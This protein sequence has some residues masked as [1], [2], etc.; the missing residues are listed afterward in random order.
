MKTITEKAKQIPVMGAYDVFVAGGGIA[1]IAAALAAARAGAKV[2]LTEKQCILGGLATAGLVT[3]YLPLCDGCGK[4]VSFAI[5]EELLKLS[6]SYGAEDRYPKPW[7]EDGSD[8][9]KAEIRYQVRFNPHLFAIEAEK[10]LVAE[11]VKILYNTQI[12][13]TV[14]DGDKIGAV[15]VENKSGRGA[16]E[17]KSVVDATGDADICKFA[18]AKTDTFKP[19]NV[20][21]AWNYVSTKDGVKLNM[22]GYCEVPD[23]DK[24]GDEPAPL[25]KERFTGL[26]GEE[27]SNMLIM[28]HTQMLNDFKKKRKEDE[29]Y[30]PVTMPT[31]PQLRMTRRI[32]GKYVL[33]DK[34]MHTY[35][36]DSIGMICDWRKRG[37]VY[38]VPFRTLYGKEVKNLIC[39]GR[40]ISVTDNMWDVSRV[41]PP[42]AVTGQAAGTAAAMTDDFASLDVKE[43]QDKLTAS[44][45][46]LHECDL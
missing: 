16:Y 37:P 14:M 23:E 38:E 27:I 10:L 36:E 20:L 3:I 12:C 45:V 5:A 25:V 15:I 44:G 7:L 29:I 9:E 19:L 2:I 17:V 13:E 22:L 41:I 34:E 42:C 4:Q 32:D 39:A 8:E 26:D 6:I 43:L 21:A 28:A 18:G 11:G 31:M 24:T 33:D 40:C 1:G 35:F 46:V 30:T